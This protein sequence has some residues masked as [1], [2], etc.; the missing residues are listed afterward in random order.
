[1]NTESNIS[2]KRI[3]KVDKSF[4]IDPY[5]I[6]WT[7]QFDS[8]LKKAALN[9]NCRNWNIIAKEM[10]N[11]FNDPRFTSKK[12]RERWSSSVNPDISKTALSDVESALLIICHHKLG[13]NWSM[14]S[15]EIPKQIG[16]AHV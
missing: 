14:I 9:N 12:C 6:E 8:Y 5:H 10:Q 16:R 3:F 11:Q 2:T 15:K 7:Y 1:M 13:N 4:S